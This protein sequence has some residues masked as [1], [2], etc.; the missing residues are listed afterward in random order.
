MTEQIVKG[1]FTDYVFLFGDCRT[2][3]SD[4]MARAACSAGKLYIL[5]RG[6]KRG[7][8]ICLLSDGDCMRIRYVC[9]APEMRRS[10]VCRALI[11]YVV[12]AEGRVRISITE[13]M[14]YADALEHLCKSLLFYKDADV[15]IYQSSRNLED[16]SKWQDYMETKGHFLCDFLIRQ[17]FFTVSFKDAQSWQTDYIRHS[18]ENS[19]Q[20][21]LPVNL[22]LDEKDRLMDPDLSFLAIKRDVS[23]IYKGKERQGV[24]A[25]YSLVSRQD[26]TSVVFEQLSAGETY[27]QTGCIFLPFARSMEAF[28][29]SGYRRAAYAIVEGN[30]RANAFRRKLL[31]KI[32][33]DVCKA[34]NYIYGGKAL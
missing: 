4:H 14:E 16:F 32:T 1:S 9:V 30:N 31:T 11:S 7:G 27:L 3:Y 22:F 15:Y 34:S 23:I 33:G 25:A 28:W 10:G 13:S 29:E 19:F 17:G 5:M 6:E 24:P 2:A 18:C 12:R 21:S 26:E 8:F 20:N